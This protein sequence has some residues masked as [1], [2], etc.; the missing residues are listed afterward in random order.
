MEQ[1]SKNENICDVFINE[2]RIEDE[3]LPKLEEMGSF[4]IEGS[5]NPKM[6][7]IIKNNYMHKEHFGEEIIEMHCVGHF[8][9][10]MITKKLM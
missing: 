10:L 3:I 5:R 2:V 7:E 1:S 4:R 6:N 9:V 8:I